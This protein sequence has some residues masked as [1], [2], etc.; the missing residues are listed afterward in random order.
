MATIVSSRLTPLV[1]ALQR[2]G[3]LLQ[4]ADTL[5]G[6]I[7]R[8]GETRATACGRRGG[9]RS[10][11]T[12]ADRADALQKLQFHGATPVLYPAQRSV[13]GARSAAK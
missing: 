4:L 10:L 6:G 13:R 12:G 11:R 1:L 7:E 3:F 2:A 8:L 5:E 9:P